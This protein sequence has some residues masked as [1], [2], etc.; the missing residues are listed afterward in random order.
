MDSDK[1]EVVGHRE[2]LAQRSGRRRKPHELGLTKIMVNIAA[3]LESV[4]VRKN[5][6]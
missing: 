5:V 2:P 3:A 4:L 6:T 1:D